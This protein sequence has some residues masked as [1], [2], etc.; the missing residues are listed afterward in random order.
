MQA[1]NALHAV[2]ECEEL[3]KEGLTLRF[4]AP[5]FAV[6]LIAEC[7]TRK[8]KGV[9]V[10]ILSEIPSSSFLFLVMISNYIM[11]KKDVTKPDV[12]KNSTEAMKDSQ[13]L[14]YANMMSTLQ[15]RILDFEEF[16]AATISVHQ[17]EGMESWEQHACSAYELFEKNGNR[18]IMIEKLASGT[19]T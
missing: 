12:T 13:I 16:C 17:L 6:S 8:E 19:W 18:P 14:D 3:N 5:S 10:S 9:K 2:Q 7:T 4:L 1:G 15:Y 11:R